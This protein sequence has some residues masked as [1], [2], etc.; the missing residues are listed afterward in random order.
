MYK[1]KS[2]QIQKDTWI[3]KI[4]I[5]GVWLKIYCGDILVSKSQVKYNNGVGTSMR[6]VNVGAILNKI[7]EMEPIKAFE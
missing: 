4:K 7:F 2:C 6:K 5:D 3:P 1:I